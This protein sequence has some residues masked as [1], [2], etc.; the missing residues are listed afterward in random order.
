MDSIA[1]FFKASKDL[2]KEGTLLYRIVYNGKTRQIDTR[3]RI[4]PEE[5]SEEQKTIVLPSNDNR[6]YSY[7]ISI[8]NDLE[9]PVVR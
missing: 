2:G 5:W 4:Y 3:F 6:N 1:L 8:R 7:L 9:L